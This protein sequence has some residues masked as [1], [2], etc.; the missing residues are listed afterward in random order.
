MNLVSEV[1]AKPAWQDA[2][3]RSAVYTFFS[4]A[5][6]Y[7]DPV[8]I[9]I[10][11][12]RILP[13]VLELQLE[14]PAGEAIRDA[15]AGLRAPLDSL[16]ARHTSLFSLTVS[17][18]CPDYETAYLSRDVFQQT[19]VMADVAGFY[20][21]HGLEVGSQLY[22]RP[23]HITTELEFMGFLTRKEAYAIEHLGEEQQEMAHEVQALFLRDHLAC[24]GPALGRRIA[25]RDEGA[26]SPYGPV[27]RALAE[28]LAIECEKFDITPAH[29]VD[30]PILEWPELDDGTCGVEAE[31]PA[32]AS[33][34][35]DL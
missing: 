17:P 35:P 22:Q 7:P 1:T 32:M 3:A 20:R 5:L 8:Q 2:I 11:Q 13:I 29:S 23:D 25:S 12:E 14:G 30:E 24:W 16:R 9:G 10:L 15:V 6:A 18:D 26:G 19:E 33:V 21:A 31:C 28:W 34:R 4:R 27:G